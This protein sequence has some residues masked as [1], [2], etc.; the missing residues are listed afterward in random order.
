MWF[1]L[2]FRVVA[3]I[4][5]DDSLGGWGKT[6][7]VVLVI[8][9]PFLGVFVYLIAR[10]RDMG[11]REVAHARA[12]QQA[13]GFCIRETAGGGRTSAGELARLSGIRARGDITEEEFRRAEELV[14]SGAS[15]RAGPVTTATTTRH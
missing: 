1:F 2:L 12:R 7:W 10:G 6:G 11:R 4:F 3:D 8:V 13:G 14:L 15:S 5:R 9:L